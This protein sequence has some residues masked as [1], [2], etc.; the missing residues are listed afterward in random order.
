MLSNL[1]KSIIQPANGRARQG[2]GVSGCRIQA[3]K[4]FNGYEK[5][6]PGI[7]WKSCGVGVVSRGGR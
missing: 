2:T 3:L 4:N 1:P 6:V 5:Q 7:T